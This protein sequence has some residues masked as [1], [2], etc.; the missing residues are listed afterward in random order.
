MHPPL[1][2]SETNVHLWWV[3]DVEFPEYAVSYLQERDKINN[4]KKTN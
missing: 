1:S 3:V 2:L 4:I